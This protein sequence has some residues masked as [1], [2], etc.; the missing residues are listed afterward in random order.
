MP[1]VS[2]EEFI[3][4]LNHANSFIAPNSFDMMSYARYYCF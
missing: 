4:S 2:R 3:E 1:D